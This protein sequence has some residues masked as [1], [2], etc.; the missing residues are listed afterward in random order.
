VVVTEKDLFVG[1]GLNNHTRRS[2]GHRL[3]QRGSLREVQKVTKRRF[4]CP[5]QKG[6]YM[7]IQIYL[8]LRRA[9][10]GPPARERDAEK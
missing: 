10:G 2:Q 6:L 5:P 4:G 7:E 3:I 1:L 8:Y 9:G